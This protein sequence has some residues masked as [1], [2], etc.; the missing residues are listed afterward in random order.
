MKR[1]R[2]P[3]RFKELGT[4]PQ[5]MMGLTLGFFCAC[6]S[7][8]K[9]DTSTAAGAF[10]QAERYA[11]DERFEEAIEKFEQVKNKHP[12]SKYA[13]EARLRI[14]DI[15][16]E[17]ESFVEAQGAYQLFKDLH[18]KHSKSAYVTFRLGMSC[19]QQLPSS[20]DRDLSMSTKA[21]QYFDEVLQSYADSDYATQSREKKQAVLK[22]LAEKELYIARYYYIR[23][24]FDSALPRYEGVIKTY[25]DSEWVVEGLFGATMS[26]HQLGEK[27][28]AQRYF[29][30]LKV[31]FPNSTQ[32]QRARSELK[33][34]D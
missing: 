34:Y 5:I 15:Q 2:E 17:K 27:D 8:D 23:D 29:S 7:G 32:Y 6:S 12:Y 22:M 31:L 1:E 11:K 24:K 33:E 16:Y 10:E 18:P 20:I 3:Q 28:K 9:L 26:A 30:Q 13:V 19:F 21:I 4:I 14:A 25:P